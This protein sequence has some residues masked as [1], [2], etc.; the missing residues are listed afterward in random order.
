MQNCGISGYSSSLTVEPGQLVLRVL[1]IQILNIP[2]VIW[3]IRACNFT[4]STIDVSNPFSVES[5]AIIDECSFTNSDITT[6]V[7]QF[8]SMDMILFQL[9]RMIEH[10]QMEVP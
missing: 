9:L 3:K 4:N 5:E 2:V 7:L 8:S 6:G 1:L 10:F